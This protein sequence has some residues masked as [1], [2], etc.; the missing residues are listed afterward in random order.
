MYMYIRQFILTVIDGLFLDMYTV[1]LNYDGVNITTIIKNQF[2]PHYMYHTDYPDSN[3]NR[4]LI[5]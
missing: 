2:Q 3:N 4:H 1:E 5:S